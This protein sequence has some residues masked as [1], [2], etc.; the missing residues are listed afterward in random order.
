MSEDFKKIGLLKFELLATGLHISSQAKQFL[1]AVKGPIRTR[2]GTSGGL[3]IVLPYEVHV[4]CPVNENFA[5]HSSLTLDYIEKSLVITR[6]QDILTS[7]RLQTIPKYY[8]FQTSDG[9][10]MI[11]IGQM[12]SGDRFCYGMTG[13][14]CW[15]WKNERR[16]KYCSIGLNAERDSSRKSLEALLETLTQAVNDIN[17]PAKHILI[18]GG[19]PEG[20]D[21]GAVLA[22]KLCRAIKK[23]FDISC[24]V[25]ICAPLKN[26]YI[27]M[28]KDAGVDELGMNIELFSDEAWQKFIPGKQMY[29][30]KKRYLE[31][32]EYAVSLFGPINTRSIILVGLEESRYTMNG[33]ELLASMG[34]MPILSPFR[35]LNGT[36][37]ESY[38]GF[39]YMTY[40]NLF[41][42]IHERIAKYNIPTGP[43]CIC[44]QNNVLAL[45][46]SNGQYRNY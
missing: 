14:Y 35:P 23:R 6:N 43:T 41:V 40:W 46:L 26:E 18:G 27:N 8:S 13:P 31:A 28:L 38:C 45:P 10:P 25:M 34:T 33:A 7:I 16:C 24:Y 12:C 17:I 22:S 11:K 36:K 30:G 21:M 2:S 39:D 15:F 37:L 9:I 44:C 5:S 42:E 20:E 32:L 3:D 29:I 19:T 1:E 4:N